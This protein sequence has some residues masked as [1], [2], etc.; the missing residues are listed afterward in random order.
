MPEPEKVKEFNVIEV[1]G[2]R[3]NLSGGFKKFAYFVAAVMCIFHIYV[4]FIS[5]ID[6]WLLRIYHLQFVAVIGFL[7]FPGWKNARSKV[8]WLDLLLILLSISTLIYV[9]YSFDELIFRAGVLPTNIDLIF[10]FF[11]VITLI[12]LTRRVTGPGLPILVLVF[13]V[14][15]WAGKY[16]PGLLWHKGYSWERT[17]SFMYSL[18]GIY[19]IPLG[20]SATYVYLFILFGSFLQITGAGKYFI[21]AAFSIAGKARGGPA[22]VAI[23]ASGLFGMINGTSAGNVVTTGSFTIPL[24]KS[25]G[26]RPAFAGAVESV[27]STGGQIMPPIMGAAAFLMAELLGVSYYNI[28]V[29]AILPAVLYYFSLYLMIDLEA[30][31][32]NLLG[33]PK[34]QLPD[35]KTVFKQ[36]YFIIPVIVLLYVLVVM[37]SSIIFAGVAG[38]LSSLVVGIA[39]GLTKKTSIINFKTIGDAMFDGALN[40]VSVAVTCAMAGMIIGVLSLTGLGMKFATIIINLAHGNLLLALVLTM[41]VTIILGMGLPT[42]AAY[43]ITASV[44]APALVKMGLPPLVAHFFVFYY[45]C[46]SAITPPVA[47]AAFAAAGIAGAKPMEVGWMSVKIGLAGF[48]VPFMFVYGKSLL[49]IGTLNEIL[50]TIFTASIGIIALALSLQGYL[51]KQISMVIRVPLFT[52]ALLLIK[53]G[54]QTDSVGLSLLLLCIVIQ[55]LAAHKFSK[56]VKG[57]VAFKADASKKV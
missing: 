2:I 44:V 30:L 25:L 52:A 22:K 1:E 28:I 8:H 31:K 51:W 50:L 47:L 48:I 10:A 17:L 5:G 43:A 6:P 55:W 15:T 35:K 9:V 49:L 41:I 36:I 45:A 33:L 40:V 29:A 18:D 37:R 39:L 46:L 19:N 34:E 24:M 27:A 53:P 13:L 54:M 38:I 14:Y 3:R 23:I 16:L 4:L 7:C 56:S 26:Y 11:A 42:I 32:L 57:D 20:T 21:D 12:E